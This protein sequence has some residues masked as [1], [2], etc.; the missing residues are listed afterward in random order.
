MCPLWTHD[1][2]NFD[3]FVITIVLDF[4]GILSAVT[5]TSIVAVACIGA[6]CDVGSKR[7]GSQCRH[8]CSHHDTAAVNS[9]EEPSKGIVVV[10][11]GRV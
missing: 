4:K 5:S 10:V 1:L 6:T 3:L 8:S 11:I 9:S 7:Y 2:D